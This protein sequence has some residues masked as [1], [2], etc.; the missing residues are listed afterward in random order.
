MWWSSSEIRVKYQEDKSNFL[1]REDDNI[2]FN[3]YYPHKLTNCG[4]KWDII[5]KN[6]FRNWEEMRKYL[7]GGVE[8]IVHETGDDAGFSD[9]LITE[10]HEFVLR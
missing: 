1:R 7:I 4:Y 5:K 3:R 10:K 6:N 8:F 2:V 9:G